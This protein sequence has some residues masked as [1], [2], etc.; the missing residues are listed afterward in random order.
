MKTLINKMKDQAKSLTN[1]WIGGK[2]I[3][4]WRKIY[5]LEHSDSIT[6]KINYKQNM[7]ELWDMIKKQA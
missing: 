3:K 2:N 7:K 4:T 5:E 6:V 1:D